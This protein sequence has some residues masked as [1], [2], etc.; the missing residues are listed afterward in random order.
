MGHEKAQNGQRG[1]LSMRAVQPDKA[2]HATIRKI[3]Q[4]TKATTCLL[5]CLK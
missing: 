3:I 5:V 2:A 4:E 1:K